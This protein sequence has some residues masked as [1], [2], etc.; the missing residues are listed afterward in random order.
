MRKKE[1]PF[2]NYS[3]KYCT[4]TAMKDFE[5]FMP[6]LSETNTTLGRLTDF[7]KVSANIH[8]ITLRIT[9]LNYPIGKQDLQAAV[10]EIYEEN[11]KP[12]KCCIFL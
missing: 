11:A 9:Q 7:G 5:R 1:E 12:L 6:R 8:K 10:H 3:F 4:Q 2:P